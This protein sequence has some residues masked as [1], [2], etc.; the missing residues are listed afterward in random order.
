MLYSTV[1]SLGEWN[2]QHSE[3]DIP[4]RRDTPKFVDPTS[5]RRVFDKTRDVEMRARLDAVFD[6]GRAGNLN[7]EF[8]KEN[9]EN[10]TSET[11]QV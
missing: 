10:K 9:R 2:F 5:T 8:L 6:M 7:K 11:L 1:V 4:G 3:I